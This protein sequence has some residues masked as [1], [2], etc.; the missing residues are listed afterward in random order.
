MSHDDVSDALQRKIVSKLQNWL[1]MAGSQAAPGTAPAQVVPTPRTAN[2]TSDGASQPSSFEAR[3]KQVLKSSDRVAAGKIQILNISSLHTRLGADDA[4]SL[5]RIHLCLEGTLKKHLGRD[6]FY[7][8]YDNENYAIV[9]P[10]LDDVTARLKTV[11]IANDVLS[12]FF[13]DRRD[14]GDLRLKSSAVDLEGTEG[15][16]GDGLSDLLFEALESAQAVDI[17]ETGS[18]STSQP[19]QNGNGDTA[20]AAFSRLEILLDQAIAGLAQLGT[21]TGPAVR[22]RAQGPGWHM[23]D[24]VGLLR[25]ELDTACRLIE[26]ARAPAPAL[27]QMAS[28]VHHFLEAFDRKL[29]AQPAEAA[30]PPAPSTMPAGSP[31]ELSDQPS[32]SFEPL[33]Q[34]KRSAVSTY[35]CVFYLQWD[36]SLQRSDSC[37]RYPLSRDFHPMADLLVLARAATELRSLLDEGR[38]CAIS[39]TV[40]ADTLASVLER[41]RYIQELSALPSEIRRLLMIEVVGFE[42]GIWPGKVLQ[43]AQSISHLPRACF[44]RLNLSYPHIPDLGFGPLSGLGACFPAKCRQDWLLRHLEGFARKTAASQLL[45]CITG[46]DTPE[47]LALARDAGVL[48]AGGTA[49]SKPLPRPLGVV[50]WSEIRQ[51]GDRSHTDG[52]RDPRSL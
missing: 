40:H 17:L 21:D 9:F 3:L 31:A 6:D 22:G 10:G 11:A 42:S 2:S 14:L 8:R 50:P 32:F 38:R 43:V 29:R 34:L 4:T 30:A 18:A 28:E 19:T 5:E 52:D 36:G 49:V 23:Q 1:G 48:Y 39:A 47:R 25:S 20:E 15:S 12:K 7:I 46:V 37:V 41:Q 26:D 45:A 27:Q 33:L 24:L 51:T 16:A 44:A 35:M 13:G